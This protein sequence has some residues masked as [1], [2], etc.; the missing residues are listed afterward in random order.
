[1]NDYRIDYA[2]IDV[3]DLMQQVR[4]R[5]RSTV[6]ADPRLPAVDRADVVLRLRNHLDMDNT[7]PYELQRKLKLDSG[8]NV[9]PGDLYTS[10]PGGAGRL[11][12]IV[13]RVLRPI[14]KLFVNLDLPLHKQFKVNIGVAAALHDLMQDNAVLR[15]EIEEL[16]AQRDAPDAN[17]RER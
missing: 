15:A 5:A 10:H 1:M 17:T 16:R 4:E 8:W 13:R 14:T 9:A 12:S 2:Q 3:D 11:I 7:Q 6:A